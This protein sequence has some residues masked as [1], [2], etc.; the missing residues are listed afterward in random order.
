M[1]TLTGTVHSTHGDIDIE[2]QNGK[3]LN[4]NTCAD[5][6][7]DIIQFDLDEYRLFYE[8]DDVGFDILDLGY[9]YRLSDGRVKYEK[10]C[11]FHRNMVADEMRAHVVGCGDAG[12]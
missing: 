11:E 9:W 6:Y 2:T 5:E 12:C 7:G 10:P 8:A 1:R 4:F 3:V